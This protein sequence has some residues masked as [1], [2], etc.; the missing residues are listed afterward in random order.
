MPVT[1]R[2]RYEI[3]RRDNHTCRYCGASAPDVFIGVDHVTPVSLGGTNEPSNL[4]AACRDCNAGKTS[5]NPA[6]PL[7]DDVKQDAIRWAAAMKLAAERR[8]E[9][10]RPFIEY[11]KAFVDEWEEYDSHQSWAYLPAT[12]EDSI[13]GFFSAGLPIADLTKAVAISMS[14]SHVEGSQKFRYMC[15][16]CWKMLTE[17]QAEAMQIVA[18]D[19]QEVDG[20]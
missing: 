5:S 4:V 8:R 14:K 11:A 12:W 3:L 10:D 2:L 13:R 17:L 16:I 15:G 9:K 19:G 1:K 18:E 6:A 20:S 7:V